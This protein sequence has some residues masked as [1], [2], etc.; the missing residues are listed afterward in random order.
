MSF[1]RVSLLII[2]NPETTQNLKI[3]SASFCVDRSIASASSHI[4][5]IVKPSLLREKHF[6]MV[7]EKLANKLM[8]CIIALCSCT[9]LQLY[10]TFI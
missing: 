6:K 2:M 1:L 10:A 7:P 3:I 4:S 5:T 9:P 8:Q